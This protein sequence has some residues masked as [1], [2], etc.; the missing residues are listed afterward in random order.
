MFNVQDQSI[1][2]MRMYWKYFTD[3]KIKYSRCLTMEN[4]GCR[5]RVQWD[6]T[7]F[8]M[9]GCKS[10]RLLPQT[11]K[12]KQCS[13]EHQRNQVCDPEVPFFP[14]CFVMEQS[15]SCD[16]SCCSAKKRKSKK[17]FFRNSPQAVFRLQF[18]QSVGKEC[19]HIES[20]VPD[21]QKRCHSF[22]SK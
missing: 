6:L 13:M 4:F 11:V 22:S 19:C 21:N 18:V 20:Y 3:E 14:A 16:G 12:K 2:V 15:A 1:W 7:S 17:K 10:C 9:D 8:I 5:Q